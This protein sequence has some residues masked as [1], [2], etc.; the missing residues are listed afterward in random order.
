MKKYMKKCWSCGG[1]DMEDMGSFVKCRGCGATYNPVNKPA[2]SLFT[3]DDGAGDHATR[4]R[5]SGVVHNRAARARGS[6]A[7]G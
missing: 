6:S 5:P 7:K 4:F 1:E 3:E 2:S